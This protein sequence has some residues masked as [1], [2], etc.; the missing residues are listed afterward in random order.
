MQVPHDNLI[1]L[2]SMTPES[3]VRS[4]VDMVRSSSPIPVVAM[5]DNL[6]CPGFLD[7]GDEFSGLVEPLVQEIL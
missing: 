5:P 1:P 6:I 4:V 7:A 2:P 3:L